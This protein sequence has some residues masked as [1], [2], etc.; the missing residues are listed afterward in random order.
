MKET[1]RERPRATATTSTTAGP[2]TWKP[3]RERRAD[4]KRMA[5]RSLRGKMSRNDR[6]KAFHRLWANLMTMSR[7]QPS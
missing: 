7:Q 4:T 1:Q 6:R 3:R 5:R 2:M